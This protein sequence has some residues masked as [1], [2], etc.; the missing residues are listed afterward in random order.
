MFIKI[1]EGFNKDDTK[2]TNAEINT[3]VTNFEINMDP[4]PNKNGHQLIS[5]KVM[6]KL[7]DNYLPN[8]MK[9][10]KT[11]VNQEKK[12]DKFDNKTDIISTMLYIVSI[13][14]IIIFLKKIIIN[15]KE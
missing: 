5:E 2:M 4:H 7:F 13:T 14:S 11:M 8:E 3:K 1:Y 10:E 6:E 9:I 15:Q 12:S